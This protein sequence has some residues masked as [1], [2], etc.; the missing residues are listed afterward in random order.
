MGHWWERW[1]DWVNGH[2]LSAESGTLLIALYQG[3]QLRSHPD[4]EGNK[5]Y[6][7]HSGEKK[8]VVARPLVLRLRDQQ[9]IETNQKFPLATYFLT[10]LGKQVAEE[11]FRRRVHNV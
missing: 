9:L 8:I 11:F 10:N 2:W 6:W 3:E 4:L 5:G 1:G 7:L